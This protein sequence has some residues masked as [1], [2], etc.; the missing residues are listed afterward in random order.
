M[1]F[2]LLL[3]CIALLFN[4]PGDWLPALAGLP[5]FQIAILGCLSL[6]LSEF[7]SQLQT[8]SAARTPISVC[9]N[10]LLVLVIL[11][12]LV[13]GSSLDVIS[14]FTKAWVLYFLVLALV[15]SLHRL[16]VILVG[17]AVSIFGI[18]LLM[19]LDH[20]TGMFGGISVI[21]SGDGLRAE[22]VGGA[23]FDAN[24]TAALLVI[25]VLIFLATTIDSRSIILRCAC[26]ALAV[27]SLHA[28]QLCNSRSSLLALM[29]GLATYVYLRWGKKGLKWGALLLPVF[30]AFVA[31]DRMANIGGA[32][33]H[34]TGQGRMQFWSMG[35]SLF[36]RN[37]ILGI[38]P[39]EFVNH[40]GKACHNSF[41][42]AF[43]ELGILGGAL[44]VGAF[45]LA[46]TSSMQLV[47]NSSDDRSNQP[48][49]DLL[50]FVIPA[51]LVAYS[52]SILTLNHLFSCHTYLL[53]A[54]STAA[55]LIYGLSEREETANTES[56]LAGRL[57]AVTCVFL[58]VTY[59]GCLTL[60][61]W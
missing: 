19:V 51:I 2:S 36:F 6:S 15:N 5:L 60:V 59:V 27:V 49:P 47:N 9:I 50:L 54:T 44:F 30:A 10:G 55:P 16:Q 38:G 52:V 56:S 48:S 14:T 26:T 39:G 53:L 58:I 31:T 35:L 11:S 25:A 3:V 13:H 57:G 24:D 12:G 23:N 37:P 8:T 46:I 20:H 18:G 42:Q 29:A 22:A 40:V 28:I 21:E 45:Y 41:V 61:Q 7:L 1:A 17:T 43:T 33:Q 4:R 34:G 32:V